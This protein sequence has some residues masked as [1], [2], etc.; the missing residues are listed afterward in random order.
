VFKSAVAAI[1]FDGF[2]IKQPKTGSFRANRRVFLQ[3]ACAQNTLFKE[4]RSSPP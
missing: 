2:A 3:A 4:N 1:G